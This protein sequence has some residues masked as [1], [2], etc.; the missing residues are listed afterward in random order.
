MTATD[1]PPA[2]TGRCPVAH[3]FDPFD[4]TPESFFSTARQER[5]VFYHEGLGAYVLTRY[6]DCKRLL[7][8]RSGAVSAS[9]ALLATSMC[10]RSPRP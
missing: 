6:E 2:P 3:D 4:G 10:S 1:H 5:P 7:G 8:D 9:A